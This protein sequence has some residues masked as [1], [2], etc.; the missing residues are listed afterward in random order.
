M[1]ALSTE[2]D[3]RS[4]LKGCSRRGKRAEVNQQKPSISQF[5]TSMHIQPL[6]WYVCH[7]AIYGFREAFSCTNM[8]VI[9]YTLDFSPTSSSDHLSNHK[10]VAVS[11]SALIRYTFLNSTKIKPCV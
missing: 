8:V 6:L 3:G 4:V 11:R 5:F 9:C 1:V 10:T 7:I 2:E